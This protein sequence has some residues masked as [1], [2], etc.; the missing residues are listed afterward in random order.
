MFS[1]LSN[2]N[3]MMDFPQQV[4]N[5]HKIANNF[6]ISRAKHGELGRILWKLAYSSRYN[7]LFEETHHDLHP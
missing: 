1:F 2:H 3:Y 4:G 6:E 7:I 5:N